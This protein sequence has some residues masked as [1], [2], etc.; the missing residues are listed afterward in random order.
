MREA[1]IN[2]SPGGG[3]VPSMEAKEARTSLVPPLPARQIGM[4]HGLIL[5]GLKL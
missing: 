5:V 2:V 3:Q 4:M 1:Y